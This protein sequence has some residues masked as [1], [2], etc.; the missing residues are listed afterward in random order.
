MTLG[1][2]APDA[3]AR[4]GRQMLAG[5]NVGPGAARYCTRQGYQHLCCSYLRRLLSKTRSSATHLFA[6]QSPPHGSARE[7]LRMDEPSTW[8]TSLQWQTFDFVRPLTRLKGARTGRRFSLAAFMFPQRNCG[9]CVTISVR[10]FERGPRCK[11]PALPQAQPVA[12]T[13][14]FLCSRPGEKVFREDSRRVRQAAVGSHWSPE[15]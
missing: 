10:N 6:A 4:P 3:A 9:V 1:R 13:S 8:Q 15:G 11:P 14:E 2:F 5:G 7:H 12:G